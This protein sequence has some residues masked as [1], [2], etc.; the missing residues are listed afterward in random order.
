[1]TRRTFL[2]SAAIASAQSRRPNIVVILADDL[3]FRNL[4]YQGGA[5]QTPNLD[6]L[7]GAGIRLNQFYSYPLC[8]PT[9]AALLTGRNPI[10]YGLA[11]S[12]VRPWSYYGLPLSEELLPAQFHRQV[13]SGT[14]E[15]KAASQRARI[16]PLLRPRERRDR[17]QH[18]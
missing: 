7:A 11:Y 16:R 10:R 2:A 15:Q 4:G 1:M 18:A 5:E 9:R 14:R 6:R 8:S 12:V 17:L 13:A 3:G